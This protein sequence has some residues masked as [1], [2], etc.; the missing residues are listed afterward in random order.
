MARFIRLTFDSSLL[1]TVRGNRFSDS[2]ALI[3]EKI[4]RISAGYAKKGMCTFQVNNVRPISSIT[5]AQQT[6]TVQGALLKTSERHCMFSTAQRDHSA[7][8]SR[9]TGFRKKFRSLNQK[10]SLSMKPPP[11]SEKQ[12]QS[13]WVSVSAELS[14]PGQY[15]QNLFFSMNLPKL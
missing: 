9:L 2:M 6:I 11:I 15:Q 14:I 3:L 13:H 7:I 5:W 8:T 12:Q 1:H 10:F 4:F